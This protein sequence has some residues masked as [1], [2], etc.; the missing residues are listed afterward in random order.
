MGKI[1]KAIRKIAGLTAKGEEIPDPTTMFQDLNMLRPESIQSQIARM[2]QSRASIDA[3]LNGQESFEEANDFA[4]GDDPEVYSSAYELS[5]E[6]DHF[7][8]QKP[9]IEEKLNEPGTEENS[10]LADTDGGESHSVDG[11]SGVSE[12]YD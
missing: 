8:A 6:I 10:K 11:Q 2:I 12:T 1:Q 5:D 3:M 7:S 4:I 9:F